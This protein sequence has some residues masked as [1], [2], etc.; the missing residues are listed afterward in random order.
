M[1]REK[2]QM[3][4]NTDYDSYDHVNTANL[5]NFI[6]EK[7]IVGARRDTFDQQYAGVDAFRQLA[8]HSTKYNPNKNMEIKG[9]FGHK[10]D[11]EK[12][13]QRKNRSTHNNHPLLKFLGKKNQN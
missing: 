1:Q 11:K 7:K 12:S 3:R 8:V 4:L 13:I 2:K 5:G 6:K 9:L 10:E